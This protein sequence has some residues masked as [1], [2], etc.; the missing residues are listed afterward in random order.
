M[1]LHMAMEK[2]AAGVIGYKVDLH[3]LE[4]AQHGHVFHDPGG[5][6]TADLC[7]LKT[8]AVQVHGV[9]VIGCVAHLQP[10]TL[11]FFQVEH[12]FHFRHIERYAVNRPAVK[13]FVGAI[14]FFKDHFDHLVRLGYAAALVPK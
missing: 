1:Q 5:M 14:L 3:L 10:I 9:N 13:A 8:M 12:G 4:T 11:A 2:G 6:F 7:Q